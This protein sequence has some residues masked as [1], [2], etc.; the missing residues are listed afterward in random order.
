MVCMH[1]TW[2]RTRRR[3]SNV[4]ACALI[5][6]AMILAI[7]KYIS[8]CINEVKKKNREYSAFVKIAD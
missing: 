1:G 3:G 8:Y 6:K 5:N 7:L 4:G 2:E